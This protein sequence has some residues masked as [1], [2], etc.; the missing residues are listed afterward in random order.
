MKNAIGMII[1]L[2]IFPA[3][4]AAADLPEQWLTVAEATDFRATSTYEQTMDYLR[5]VEAEAPAIIRVTD[6][7]LSGQ[8]RPLPLVIVS[9]DG[10]FT[11]E[12]AAATGK[13]ILLLQSCIHAGEVDGKDASL[14][15]LRD[16]ALGRRP[17][18]AEGP[19]VLFAPIYNLDGHEN[20]S[21]YHRA[22]QDGPVE[23]QGYRANAAGINL[24][25][26][27]L[28]LASPEARAMAAL[29][30][31]WDPDLHVDNHVTNGSDHAWV[32]TWLVAEAPQL[33]PALDEWV[34]EHLTKV[35]ARTG[36]AGHPNGPYVSLVS[37]SDPTKGMIWDVAQPRYS[38][39]YFPLRNRVSIL[40]E[41]HAH[42][43]FRDRVM[44]N[45]VFMEELILEVGSAGRALKKAVA[46]AESRTVSLGG[47]TAEP[48]EIVLRWKVADE[49]ENMR[50]PAFDWTTENS[51]VTGGSRIVYQPGKI[52]EIELSWRHAPQPE[53]SLPRPRGYLVAA[54]WPQ[55]E[56]VV[57]GHG[58]RAYRVIEGTS[59]DVETIR[60]SKPEFATSSYQGV[61][62]VGDFEVSRQRERRDVPAN[63]LWIPADQPAFE[64][65]VQLFEPEAP[66]SLIRWGAL[67]SVFERKIY[68]GLDVLEELAR[69]M[70][71]DPKVRDAWQAAIADEEFAQ[72]WRARYLWW[73]QRTPYWDESV[74]LMPVFRVHTN[75]L[76]DLE[77]WP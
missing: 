47:A 64:V 61:V 36:K 25:R 17:E 42:K 12:A 14:M 57:K 65:A 10:A 46:A 54:G 75:P 19:I 77:P 34:H 49:G 18:L 53:L 55:I 32:L 27:F 50:W 63:S 23:G 30:D 13:P 58:L 72:D 6:F 2:V 8:G 29:V 44:A 24:N 56:E 33:D 39:G 76:L 48:S 62:M 73:Y 60:L 26:D 41:M 59:L 1:S 9:A 43:P 68:V 21:P 67:S 51:V 37:G 20:V 16:I 70:L 15:I 28:R 45:R 7:G 11:P 69:E 35:L 74:G 38:S 4:T 5:R 71:E 31:R 3:V 22:N 66:D 40:I 52:R